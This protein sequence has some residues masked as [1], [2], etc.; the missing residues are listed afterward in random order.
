MTYKNDD[1]MV[2]N[3]NISHIYSVS[4]L[5]ETYTINRLPLLL[6]CMKF[7]GKNILSPVILP[8]L[9]SFSL[10]LLP[11]FSLVS[12]TILQFQYVSLVKK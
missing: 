12:C 7:Q 10:L 8:I 2:V 1:R 4:F 3:L 9:Y 5:Q 6:L 11:P